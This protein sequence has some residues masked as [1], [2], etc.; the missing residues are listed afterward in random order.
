MGKFI[1]VISTH[2]TV[3]RK[4]DLKNGVGF[5]EEILRSYSKVIDT[6]YES[7]T[8][9]N[10]ARNELIEKDYNNL[11][12]NAENVTKKIGFGT[13]YLEWY[14]HEEHYVKL[15]ELIYDVYLVEKDL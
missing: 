1:H 6:A 7:G 15:Y 13:C 5:R 10:K 8:E 11:P 2:E 14:I 12:E 4:Q 3:S 9:A